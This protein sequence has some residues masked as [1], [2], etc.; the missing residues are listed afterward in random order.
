M[1][2]AIIKNVLMATNR[3]ATQKT[4]VVRFLNS[5]MTTNFSIREEIILD[6]PCIKST[7]LKTTEKSRSS[8]SNARSLP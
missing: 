3:M 4:M 7:N 8:V 2:T 6:Y 1:D 5:R